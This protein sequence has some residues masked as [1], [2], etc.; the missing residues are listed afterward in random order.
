MAPPSG[1]RRAIS[2][3]IDSAGTLRYRASANYYNTD[4]YIENDYLHDKADPF[5]DYSGRLRLVWKPTDRFT[6]DLRVLLRPGR[7]YRLLLCHS[8]QRRIQPVHFPDQSAECERHDYA[9]SE[10]QSRHRTIATC[11]I[12][13]SSWI[14]A[15]TTG[16]SPRSRTTTTPRRSTPATPSISGRSRLRCCGI[17][18]VAVP[19]SLGG[20]FDES[21]SQFIDVTTWSQELRFTSPKV[22]GFSWIAGAY[23][24]HTDRFISTGNLVDRGYGRTSGLSRSA[25]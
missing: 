15:W 22:G 10:Q 16:R 14:L 20:P 24:L 25:G 7:D 2:G 11:L 21:Q 8:A 17:S 1:C 18:P 23:Y 4:G 13:P 19:D 6:G 5:K 12:P 9:D 3:P